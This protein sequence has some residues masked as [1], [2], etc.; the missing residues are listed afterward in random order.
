MHLITNGKFQIGNKAA[1]GKAGKKH[2]TTVLRE[3]L[4][5]ENIEDLKVD[6]LNVWYDFLHSGNNIEKGF[7]AKELSKYL[8]SKRQEFSQKPSSIAELIQKCVREEKEER[9]LDVEQR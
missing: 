3:K 5:I 2:K 6:V 1:A 9:L 7:A 8:F 4:G